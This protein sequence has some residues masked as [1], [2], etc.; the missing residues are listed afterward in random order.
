M[1]WYWWVALGAAV[2]VGGYVKL[3]VL[4]KWMEKRKNAEL[5]IPEEE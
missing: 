2:L 3:K 4:G 5:N 1:E